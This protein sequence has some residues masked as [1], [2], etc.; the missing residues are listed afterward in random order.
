M[1]NVQMVF[2][3]MVSAIIAFLGVCG[4]PYQLQYKYLNFFSYHFWRKIG[5]LFIVN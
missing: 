2:T 5:E 1:K 4:N 3:N